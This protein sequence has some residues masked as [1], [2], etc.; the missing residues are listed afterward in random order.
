[1]LGQGALRG[2]AMAQVPLDMPAM[3]M[4]LVWHR[5]HQADP[6]QRWLRD[7]LEAQVAELGLALPVG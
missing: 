6:V 2:L 4:Y 5:R 3:P 1:L 7:A